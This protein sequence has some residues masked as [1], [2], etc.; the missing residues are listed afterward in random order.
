MRREGIQRFGS[1]PS[2]H[3]VRIRRSVLGDARGL[4]DDSPKSSNREQRK[5]PRTWPKVEGER[6]R[7]A[8]PAIRLS[9]GELLGDAAIVQE[10]EP[11]SKPGAARIA[12]LASRT[13]EAFAELP[14]VGAHLAVVGPVG[15]EPRKRLPESRERRVPT[16]DVIVPCKP[17][18]LVALRRPPSLRL[19]RCKGEG[20]AHRAPLCAASA[21]GW[22]PVGLRSRNGG[23][24]K[25]AQRTASLRGNR[26]AALRSPGKIEKANR[27]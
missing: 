21:A 16:K 9:F 24:P 3:S 10:L 1:V 19:G 5:P 18:E 25:E 8:V 6:G 12:E 23:G 22:G 7:R 20:G 2:W 15:E 11:R 26:R 4:V 17:V 13:P 27:A 14:R